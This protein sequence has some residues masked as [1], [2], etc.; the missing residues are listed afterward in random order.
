MITEKNGKLYTNVKFEKGKQLKLTFD[1]TTV[2]RHDIEEQ[3]VKLKGTGNMEI[4]NHGYTFR[5]EKEDGKYNLSLTVPV[6]KRAVL[7]ENEISKLEEM[8][9]EVMEKCCSSSLTD[10]RSSTNLLSTDPVEF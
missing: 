6:V 10:S 4:S 3:L 7:N 1:N 2:Q 9:S 8:L 5:V